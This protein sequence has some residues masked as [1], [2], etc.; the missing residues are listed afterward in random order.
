MGMVVDGEVGA[1]V[2]VA[3]GVGVTEGWKVATNGECTGVGRV[4]GTLSTVKVAESAPSS[5]LMVPVAWITWE[6][7][8]GNVPVHRVAPDETLV[9]NTQQGAATLTT[10]R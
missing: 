7:P 4:T 9:A 6:A 2:V 3:P 1:S 8:V 5:T 10:T